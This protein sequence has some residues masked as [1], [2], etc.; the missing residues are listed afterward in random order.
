MAAPEETG[1]LRPSGYVGRLQELA[2]GLAS[3]F[4]DLFVSW[5]AL[6]IGG[7]QRLRHDLATRPEA[8]ADDEVLSLCCSTGATDRALLERDWT[9]RA[10][11]ESW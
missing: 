11:T 9:A 3:P 7:E 5:A 6:P 2:Y 8:R 4:Y 10:S 1:P